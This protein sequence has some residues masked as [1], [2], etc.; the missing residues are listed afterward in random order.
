MDEN[1]E[2]QHDFFTDSS[3]QPKRPERFPSVRKTPKPILV[4]TS[5]EQIL[6]AVI[7]AILVGCLVFFLGVLRG[8][9][10]RVPARPVAAVAVKAAVQA[11]TA[12]VPAVRAAAAPAASNVP[13]LYTIQLA[14]Y[15]KKEWAQAEASKL[16]RAGHQA[17][18]IAAQGSYAVCVGRY[19]GQQQALGDLRYFSAKYP[20]AF[21]RRR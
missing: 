17:A 13:L 5:A 11:R 4:T 19:A 9:S 12:A 15:K 10:L 7:G 21:L 1:P 14:S 2:S 3:G 6:L 20:R 16:I 8:K 18:V